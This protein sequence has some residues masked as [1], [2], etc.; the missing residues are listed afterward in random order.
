MAGLKHWF[1]IKQAE[2][3][4]KIQKQKLVFWLILFLFKRYIH[5]FL[6][7]GIILNRSDKMYCKHFEHYHGDNCNVRCM[8]LRGRINPQNH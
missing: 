4:V 6:V 7:F 2:V 1:W 8:L 5:A 3:E